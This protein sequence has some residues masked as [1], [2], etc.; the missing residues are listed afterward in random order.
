M[1]SDCYVLPESFFDF[2]A[3]PAVISND[4]DNTLEVSQI[5]DRLFCLCVS[6]IVIPEFIIGLRICFGP[7]L[8][9]PGTLEI[10]SR[11]EEIDGFFQVHGFEVLQFAPGSCLREIHGFCVCEATAQIHFRPSVEVI[12]G[13]HQ[14]RSLTPMSFEPGSRA[15]E[16]KGFCF[17]LSLREIVIPAPL[18][19]IK[20]FNS[21][22]QLFQFIFDRSGSIRGIY[23]FDT[24]VSLNQLDVPSTLEIVCGFHF[25]IAAVWSE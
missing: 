10:L 23:G 7:I 22:V 18:A 3:I 8:D 20:R 11:I 1:L 5:S 14:C 16:L 4:G 17:S 24:C 9:R 13:F 12:D 6:S 25:T 21:C 2:A 19:I 15:R